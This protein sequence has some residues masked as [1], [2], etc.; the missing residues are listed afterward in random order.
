MKSHRGEVLQALAFFLRQALD[1]LAGEIA[2]VGASEIQL[3][4]VFLG[5]L[6]TQYGHA[7]GQ[8]H[9]GDSLQ[10]LNH[11]GLLHLQLLR[12]GEHLPLASA[13]RSKVLAQ[14]FMTQ[15]AGLDEPD[16]LAVP[17]VRLLADDTQ[18][19]YIAGDAEGHKDDDARLRLAI[20]GGYRISYQ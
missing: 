14:W 5:L 7:L 10:L 3:V 4:A 9:L 19:D 11:L 6:R 13:A 16:H 1:L 20:V 2:L 18:V 17:V 8:L 12:V 15:F